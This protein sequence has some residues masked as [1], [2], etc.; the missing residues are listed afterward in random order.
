MVVISDA[1]L[2]LIL[3]FVAHSA[4]NPPKES[5]YRAGP[6][7]CLMNWIVEENH[8][9]EIM[10]LNSTNIVLAMR[11]RPVGFANEPCE[12]CCQPSLQ[13]PACLPGNMFVNQLKF[14]GRRSC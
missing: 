6:T 14:A 8:T 4:G 9:D 1:C 7:C 2:S 12:T 3:L 10:A 13:Y 5:L 11:P